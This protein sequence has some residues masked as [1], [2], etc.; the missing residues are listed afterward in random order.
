MKNKMN[1]RL[2][3]RLGDSAASSALIIGSSLLGLQWLRW[4]GRKSNLR[5]SKDLGKPRGFRQIELGHCDQLLLLFVYS[6]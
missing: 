4:F 5:P 2:M 6:V 3:T 1:P